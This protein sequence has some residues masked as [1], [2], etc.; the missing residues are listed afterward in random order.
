M[1]A[2]AERFEDAGA[3]GVDEDVCVGEEGEEEG[4]GGR[5]FE[6]EGDGGLVGR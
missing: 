1:G 6:V 4:T 5:V 2:E 3:E